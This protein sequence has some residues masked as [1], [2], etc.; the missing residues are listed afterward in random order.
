VIVTDSTT[1]PAFADSL[2]AAAVTLA[3]VVGTGEGAELG[4]DVVKLATRLR[5]TT[6]VYGVDSD[7]GGTVGAP[8]GIETGPFHAIEG[9]VSSLI[10]GYYR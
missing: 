1:L 2:T 3:V 5:S 4:R 9:R 10:G 8:D 6:P 7:D